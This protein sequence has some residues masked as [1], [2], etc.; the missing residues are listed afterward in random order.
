[1]P[2]TPAAG[3][4]AVGLTVRVVRTRERGA[5]ERRGAARPQW[6][7]GTKARAGGARVGVH[8]AFAAPREKGRAAARTPGSPESVSTTTSSMLVGQSGAAVS[9]SAGGNHVPVRRRSLRMAWLPLSTTKTCG[10]P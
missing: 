4:R 8:G 1:M 2:G 9:P 3:G 6:L 10:K 7:S 5:R